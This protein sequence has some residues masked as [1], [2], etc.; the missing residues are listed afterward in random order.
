MKRLSKSLI[1]VGLAS[2][3]AGCAPG[4]GS[5]SME[6]IPPAPTKQASDKKAL[7]GCDLD[8]ARQTLRERIIDGKPFWAKVITASERS[9]LIY[10]AEDSKFAIANPIIL[11]CGKKVVAYVGQTHGIKAKKDNG[12]NPVALVQPG[13]RDA[14]TLV[15]S[16]TGPDHP[17]PGVETLKLRFDR[18]E[19]EKA[20]KNI[21]TNRVSTYFEDNRGDVYGS[22]LGIDFVEALES[23]IEP[24]QP[25]PNPGQETLSKI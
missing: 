17:N 11:I 3:V 10:S 20:A 15:I 18:E 24:P 9:D 6:K 19:A 23:T 25:E 4:L 12:Y 22:A 16:S 7:S 14:K 13:R 1:A 2:A 21:R 5:E 8:E